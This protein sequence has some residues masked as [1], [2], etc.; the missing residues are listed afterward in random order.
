[1]FL[2]TYYIWPPDEDRYYD[3]RLP[4]AKSEGVYTI[5]TYKISPPYYDSQANQR[6]S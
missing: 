5:S 4:L 6:R 1:M 3:H 2:L